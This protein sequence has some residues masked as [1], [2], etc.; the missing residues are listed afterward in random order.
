MPRRTLADGVI[1]EVVAGSLCPQ[2]P[3]FAKPNYYAFVDTADLVA[4]ILEVGLTR[5]RRD[6]WLQRIG[7][8]FVDDDAHHVDHAVNK[9][10]RDGF[11]YLPPDASLLQVH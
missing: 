1:V 8:L 7:N 4:A 3:D 10:G 6:G 5:P 2:V 11:V 9:S